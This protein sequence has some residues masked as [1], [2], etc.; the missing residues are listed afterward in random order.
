MKSF[1]KFENSNSILSFLYFLFLFCILKAKNFQ[2]TLVDRKTEGGFNRGF[3]D[4]QDGQDGTSKR[5]E[6]QN[7]NLVVWDGEKVR[8]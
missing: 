6:F 7:E 5:V 8:G 1:E 4:V 3:F 2:V